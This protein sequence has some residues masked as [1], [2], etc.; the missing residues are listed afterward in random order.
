MSNNNKKDLGAA[1]VQSTLG[2]IVGGLGWLALGA[3]ALVTA[4]HAVYITMQWTNLDPAGGDIFAILAIIGVVLVEVF[5]VFIAI[6]FATHTIRAKQKPVAMSIEGVWF[7][8]AAINMISSFS[9][10][11]GGTPPSFVNIW[12]MIG[13][14]VAGLVTGG[15]FYVVKRLDPA[16]K[17]D[18]DKAEMDESFASD[19]HD[20]EMEVMDSD[21]MKVVLRQA[22]WLTVPARIGRRLNL[23][24]AQIRHLERQAPQLLDLNQNGV[25][26]I[27][28]TQPAAAARQPEPVASP[29]GHGPGATNATNR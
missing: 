24:D 4:G 1:A 12:I 15:L 25:P 29:N 10:H 27:R 13:L 19:M 23:S 14:P 6:M 11:H 7:M 2:S 17:R 21:Q 16:A 8:F 26:D 3:L 9:M 18:E 22:M 28:E 20:A 5:A